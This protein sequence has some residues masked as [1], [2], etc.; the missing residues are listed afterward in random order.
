MAT[1]SLGT[2]TVDLIARTGG[3]ERGMDAAQRRT[4]RASRQIQSDTERMQRSVN[5]VILA[6]GAAAAAA[7]TAIAAMSSAPC[8]MM[9][10][11]CERAPA[12]GVTGE[13]CSELRYVADEHAVSQEQLAGASR[14]LSRGMEHARRGP[15]AGKR[16]FAALGGCVTDA[17]G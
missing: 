9:D 12:T 15:G 2:L 5:N 17:R 11:G 13:V 8:R 1:R 3:F 6:V 7:R 4:S 14:R 16:A 10:G